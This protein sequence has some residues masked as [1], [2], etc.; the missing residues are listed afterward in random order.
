M[1]MRIKITDTLDLHGFDPIELPL[2]LEDYIDE[3]RKRG[4]YQVR[5]IHG[6]GKGILRERVHALLRR[7]PEVAEFLLAPP[8]SG[9]WGATIVFLKRSSR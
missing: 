6:K 5:I 7:N 9:G 3:C 8:H 2:L 1:M 4:F